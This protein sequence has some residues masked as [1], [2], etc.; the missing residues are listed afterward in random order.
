M[1][2]IVLSCTSRTSC[3]T[4]PEK[5]FDKVE[6]DSVIESLLSLNNES[7]V[8]IND[9][10]VNTNTND[11]I[12]RLLLQV[13][14]N[15]ENCCDT[16]AVISFVKMYDSYPIFNIEEGEMANEVVYLLFLKQT[17]LIVN[18]MLTNA[19]NEQFKYIV[20]E[21]QNPTCD[22]FDILKIYNKVKE[23]NLT[24]Q[25]KEDIL[26]AIEVAKNKYISE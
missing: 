24:N 18:V 2:A 10:L 21:L 15:I 16:N 11:S 1:C 9:S 13:S 22:T 26:E 19:T 23:I 6:N 3:N 17:D 20:S 5:L 8:Q 14:A 12:L 25:R 4:A 7:F